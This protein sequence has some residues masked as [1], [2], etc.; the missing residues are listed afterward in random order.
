MEDRR[1]RLLP[2]LIA[3]TASATLPVGILAWLFFGWEATIAV[4]VVGWLLLVPALSIGYGMSRSREI[5]TDTTADVT[6]E[7]KRSKDRAPHDVEDDRSAL[8]TLRERFARGEIDDAEFE[9]RLDEL[10][11]TDPDEPASRLVGRSR[12]LDRE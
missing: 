10:L 3:I 7:T 4:L 1:D 2:A 6:S 9:R 5:D 12:D 8:D 11:E